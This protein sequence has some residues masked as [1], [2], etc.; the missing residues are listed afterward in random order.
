MLPS[1]EQHRYQ[2]IPPPTSVGASRWRRGLRLGGIAPE[3]LKIRFEFTNL[4]GET[5]THPHVVEEVHDSVCAFRCRTNRRA[6]KE[7]FRA[8]RRLRVGIGQALLLACARQRAN[9]SSLSPP[10]SVVLRNAEEPISCQN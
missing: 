8:R 4:S 2:L 9:T 7:H 1:P 3:N 10:S 5:G 6:R